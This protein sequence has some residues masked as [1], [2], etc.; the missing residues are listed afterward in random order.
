MSALRPNQGWAPDPIVATNPVSATGHWYLIPSESSSFLMS[1]LVSNSS[2]D[3]SGYSW[4][5]LR[6]LFNQPKN[7]AS[8]AESKSSRVNN[9]V[10]KPGKECD[11]DDEQ[12]D[13]IDSREKQ[14]S[15]RILSILEKKLLLLSDA[16]DNARLMAPLIFLFIYLFIH[17]VFSP[18][19]FDNN[20]GFFSNIKNANWTIRA[21]PKHLRY[22]L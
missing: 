21:S 20:K 7:W 13:T 17:N 12:I 16:V 4:I 5:L 1:W 11:C 9:S 6:T 10:S 3:N 8:L 18:L 2:N 19:R 15:V 14:K 22:K